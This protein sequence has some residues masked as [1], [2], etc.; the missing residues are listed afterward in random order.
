MAGGSPA[1]LAFGAVWFFRMAK[2]KLRPRGCEVLLGCTLLG[3][4]VL[5]YFAYRHLRLPHEIAQNERLASAA[6][7]TLAVAEADFRGNDLDQNGVQ[8]F[9]TGD[10]ATLARLNLIERGVG[11]ADGAPL[12]PGAGPPVAHHGYYFVAMRWD[13]SETPREDLRQGA[14]KDRHPSKFAFCAYPVKYGV[15]GR[16]TFILNEGNTILWRHREAEP[17]D[18]WPSDQDLRHEWAKG[19]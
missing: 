13:E 11:A 14:S 7:K 16:Q 9:W 6:L 12:A 17:L 10:V 15:T 2:S 5:G 3:M 18:H 1:P 19:D 8:D 4:G